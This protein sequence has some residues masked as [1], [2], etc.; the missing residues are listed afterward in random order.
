MDRKPSELLSEQDKEE[1]LKGIYENIG[2]EKFQHMVNE[3][4]EDA[5]IDSVINYKMAEY[6]K[7]KVENEKSKW[8]FWDWLFFILTG[9]SAIFGGIEFISTGKDSSFWFSF[10]SLIFIFIL[11]VSICHWLFKDKAKNFLIVLKVVFLVSAL[12]AGALYIYNRWF[13]ANN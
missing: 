12:V 7:S 5:L 11:I 8:G 1:I 13:S 9:I 10:Y 6:E 3:F 4:G 2:A